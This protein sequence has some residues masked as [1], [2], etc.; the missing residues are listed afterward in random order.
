MIWLCFR[1]QSTSL[2]LIFGVLTL[3]TADCNISI[4][5]WLTHYTRCI[6]RETELLKHLELWL[7]ESMLLSIINIKSKNINSVPVLDL[8]FTHN[9]LHK[10]IFSISNIISFPNSSHRSREIQAIPTFLCNNAVTILCSYF[11][12]R[13]SWSVSMSVWWFRTLSIVITVPGWYRPLSTMLIS[14]LFH[15]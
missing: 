9:P 11:V 15:G 1:Y 5:F 2:I 6:K 4:L 13:D 14:P 10:L 12:P 3:I 7:S 8:H